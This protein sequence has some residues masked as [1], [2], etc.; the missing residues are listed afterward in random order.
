MATITR[1]TTVEKENASDEPGAGS[2]PEELDEDTIRALTDIEG[3]NEVS[4]QIHRLSEP[5]SGYCGEMSTAELS[6]ERIASAYGPGQYR[7]KGVRPDGKYFKSG[8]VKISSVPRKPELSIEDLKKQLGGDNTGFMP[9]LLAMMNSNTS[10]VTAALQRPQQQQSIPW[11]AIIAATPALLT[12]AKSFFKNESDSESMEKILK[13]LT[14]LD[15]LRGD[16]GKGSTWQDIVRDGLSAVRGMVPIPKTAAQPV[17]ARIVPTTPSDVRGQIPVST[18]APLP[19]TPPAVEPT[20]E[21]LMMNWIRKKLDELTECAAQ[22]KNPELRAEVLIDDLPPF[23]PENIIKDM[24]TREDWFE[25]LAAFD[26]RVSNYFGW[27][28]ELRECVLET[29]EENGESN[30]RIKPASDI[31]GTGG[32][33]ETASVTPEDS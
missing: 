29:L 17:P 8:R 7:V 33:S 9:L 5:N 21:N 27:F 30:D 24:L 19:E 26:P 18:T 4:W 20:A 31:A 16:D 1:T 23:I 10:I 2:A 22:N 12:A 6:H 15:R 32:N 25:Q 28:N 3:A 14:I 11:A 13:Q